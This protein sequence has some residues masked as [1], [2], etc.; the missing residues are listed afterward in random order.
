MVYFYPVG[1][2]GRLVDTMMLISIHEAYGCGWGYMLVMLWS[3]LLAS[4]SVLVLAV[5]P[6]AWLPVQIGFHCY[7][8]VNSLGG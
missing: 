4:R 8:G 3:G 2:H 5:C 7:A 1:F 6:L